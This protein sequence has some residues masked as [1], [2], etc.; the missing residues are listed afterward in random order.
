MSQHQSKWWLA[1]AL[2]CLAPMAQA[3]QQAGCGVSPSAAGN[4]C[5][6]VEEG[7]SN[8]VYLLGAGLTCLGAILLRARRTKAR[9]S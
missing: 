9:A 7:G 8:L 4:K 1:A 5:Q 6:Q 3:G 2:V